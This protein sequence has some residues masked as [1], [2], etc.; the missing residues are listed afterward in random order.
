[1]ASYWYDGRGTKEKC[2][3]VSY[4]FISLTFHFDRHVDSPRVLVCVVSSS[5][6]TPSPLDIYPVH[7]LLFLHCATHPKKEVLL[8]LPFDG[9][10][11][12]PSALLLLAR[13]C[14]AGTS[15]SVM[16]EWCLGPRNNIRRRMQLLLLPPP[17]SGSK[18]LAGT[19]RKSA[20][21]FVIVLLLLFLDALLIAEE[22]KEGW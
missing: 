9:R 3:S 18:S 14:Q 7:L 11:C 5:Q 17:S 13:K 1:M 20:P 16:A 6:K 8:L 2:Q 22:R 21:F 10:S 15:S 12:L 19:T 4:L